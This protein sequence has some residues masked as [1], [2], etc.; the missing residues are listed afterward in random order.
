M[1][2]YL[3]SV[4]TVDGTSR[5]PMTEAEMRQLPE[6]IRQLEEDMNA[7]GA[8][9]FSGRLTD[10]E[11]AAVVRHA[12]GEVITTDGPFVEAKEHIAGFYIIQADD[13]D[14]ALAWAARTTEAV[15][16]PIELRPFWEPPASS[17]AG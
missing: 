2:Q 15:G 17:A 14:T 16:A 1:S 11:A 6:K 4:H 8:L 13:L 3:L 7:V 10:A 12:D 9:L 5:A